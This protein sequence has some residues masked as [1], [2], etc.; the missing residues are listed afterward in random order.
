MGD[1]L[2]GVWGVIWVMWCEGG[3]KR[4]GHVVWAV[5]DVYLVSCVLAT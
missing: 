1:V 5:C 3:E 4:V 2:C